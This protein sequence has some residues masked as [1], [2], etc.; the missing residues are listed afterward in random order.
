MN[1]GVGDTEMAALRLPSD[2]LEGHLKGDGHPYSPGQG[3]ESEERQHLLLDV[4][5]DHLIT[6]VIFDIIHAHKLYTTNSNRIFML[7]S[8]HYY[9]KGRRTP[10]PRHHRRAFESPSRDNNPVDNLRYSSNYLTSAQP[11]P[12]S[13]IADS[14]LGHTI[15]N[16]HRF[17]RHYEGSDNN[18]I[19]YNTVQHNIKPSNLYFYNWI[20][21][22]ITFSRRI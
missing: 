12:D 13:T 7:L 10:S 18:F 4:D 3:R 6:K 16:Q 14:E 1:I 19:A 5:M 11:Q 22:S 8:V 20:R 2:I 17:K 9:L 15:Y 21:F